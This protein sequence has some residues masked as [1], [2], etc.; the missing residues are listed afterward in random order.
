MN[1]ISTGASSSLLLQLAHE[2]VVDMQPPGGVHQE[3]VFAGVDGFAARRAGQFGRI[4]LFRRALID[5]QPDLPPDHA[6][7]LAS[8]R[9]VDVHGNHQ[10]AVAIAGKPARQL[11]GGGGLAGTLQAHQED[12]AG[13]L[14]GEAQLG[15]V[16]A[17]GL[18]QFLADDLDDLLG[19][20]QRGQHLLPEGLLLNVL[21]ELL[22]HPEVNVGL[23]QGHPDLA[24]G[25]LH[26]VDGEL[27]F[28]AQV[29]EDALE[30]FG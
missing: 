6:Q 13:R 11:A 15:L 26:V 9:T 10:R 5:R 25:A 1:R 21:D 14:V 29:L 18:D 17:Q 23:Q 7:L 19:G 22:D 24:Q 8:G 28:A 2:L 30:L 27:A 12:D 3:H 4:F 20:R 16:A